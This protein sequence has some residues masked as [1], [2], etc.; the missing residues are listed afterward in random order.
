[1]G[2]EV[3]FRNPGDY[4]RELVEAGEFR[5]AW[6]RGYLA[7]KKIDPHKHGS[8]YFGR[9]YPWEALLIGTQGTAHINHDNPLSKPLA[10]YP[11]WAYGDDVEILEEIVQ[12]PVGMDLKI[13]SDSS[14]PP[15]ERP[16]LGQPHT[17][18]ITDIPDARTGP[19]RKFLRFLKDLQEDH[20][21]CKL[22]I[23]GLYSFRMAFGLGF[24]AADYE[25]RSAAQKGKLHTPAGREEKFEKAISNPQWVT[26]LGFKP[27]DMQV[28]RN[29]CIYNI[30]SAVW[31]GENYEK[32]YKFNTGSSKGPV[33]TT[34]PDS[35]YEPKETRSHL[36]LT[37]K[38]KDGDQFHCDTCS[39]QQTCKYQRDGAVCSVPGAEPTALSRFFQT[40]DSD[41]ILDGLGVLMAAQT[42]RLERGMAEEEDF[43]ELSPEVTKL[44]TTIFNQGVTLAKLVN[45]ELRGGVK[46][47]VNTGGG[48]AAVSVGDP[49][50]MVAAV[51]R[52]FE[53]QGFRRDQITEGMIQGMLEGM[54]NPGAQ[55]QALEQSRVIDQSA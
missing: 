38:P 12:Q 36:S 32:L 45:P 18:V 11:T 21:E 13:C 19:G 51:I 47:N 23:H 5:V 44:L 20:P 50:Q 54:A 6:D 15:D 24:A 10:V 8:L 31:A 9:S 55:Q 34:T 41:M 4:V 53:R 17:V 27:V 42:K 39:L 46:V 25:P 37:V 22:F 30:K 33:D 16:V 49:R 28:P 14:L 48:A 1:M 3:W 29:R 35:E 52:E 40:R 26:V 7:K 43:G 2:T